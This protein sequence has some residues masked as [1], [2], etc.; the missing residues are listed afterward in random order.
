[1]APMST[2]SAEAGV[3]AFQRREWRRAFT[4]LEA[5]DRDGGLDPAGMRRLAMVS[6]LLGRD[7]DANRAW[8]RAHRA[9]MDAGDHALAAR[10]A[11]EMGMT[12]M[13]RGEMA[14]AG[15]WLARAS[16]IVEESGLDCPERGYIRIPEGLQL[17]DGGDAALAKNAFEDVLAVG[18]RFAD[19]DL[20]ALGRLG[21]GRSLA[22]LGR[23]SEGTA[24]LDEAMVAVTADEVS[25]IISGIIY[26]AVIE[27]CHEMFDLA[28]AQEWTG[29]LAN[30][31]ESQPEMVPFRGSC[32]VYRAEIMQF[33]GEWERAID[34]AR[35]AE[36]RL[37]GPPGHPAI[38]LAYYRQGELHR[39]R[40]ALSDADEAF[41][42]SEEWGHR[43]EPGRA[44]LRLGQGR[45]EAAVTAIRHALD[46]ARDEVGRA[47][48]LPAAVE[49]FTGTANPSAARAVADELS[50]FAASFGS[51]MLQ[52]L[53]EQAQGS[54]SLATG[55]PAEA[56]SRLRSALARW[57]TLNVPY[58]T[59]RT[60][61]LLAAAA[62]LAGDPETAATQME[63]ARQAFASLGAAADLRRLE[64]GAGPAGAGVHGL[65]PR[66]LEVLR[67]IATGM[68]NRAIAA[69]L[70]ISEK[71]VANHVGNI[72]GKLGLSSR[73]AATAYAYEHGLI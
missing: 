68:T 48:L 53:A 25:P 5:A 9:Y 49:I 55:E 70:T 4:E 19:P 26:C 13:E 6:R 31:C 35:E 62:R 33:D 10:C 17:I 12:Y 51:P 28:R 54:V 32:Q 58:E 15:G 7:D 43:P 63:L 8:E 46:E 16:R 39:L 20:T 18:R 40:G 21:L 23:I 52:A 59:A 1:M 11:F 47:G 30:W 34:E 72:L 69:H 41:R 3:D 44:L 22:G 71:T 45:S 37:A 65:T 73:A 60:R 50:E 24:H 27:M 61:A 14:Q 56:A 36:R 29:A 66:E 42:K 38:A 57:Q 64:E 67:L 2:E